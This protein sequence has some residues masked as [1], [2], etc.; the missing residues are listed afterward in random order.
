MADENLI[1]VEPD[2]PLQVGIGELLLWGENNVP[3]LDSPFATE[4][5]SANATL[6]AKWGKV[7]LDQNSE[8]QKKWATATELT[9]SS[10]DIA[11]KW[12]GKIAL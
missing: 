12:A 7:L 5:Q 8:I 11:K 6:Q 4:V 9:V 3:D 2:T 1:L 10:P